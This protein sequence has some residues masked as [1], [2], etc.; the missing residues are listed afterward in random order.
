MMPQGHR[1]RRTS[2][3]RRNWRLNHPRHGATAG[4]RVPALSGAWLRR[5]KNAVRGQSHPLTPLRDNVHFVQRAIPIHNSILH[6]L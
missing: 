6:L 5:E 2:G 3:A 1:L 4:R